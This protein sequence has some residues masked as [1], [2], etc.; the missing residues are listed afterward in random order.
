MW[1]IVLA[2]FAAVPA[3]WWLGRRFGHRAG[4]MLAT[5]P[6]AVTAWLFGQLPL[7][8]GAAREW[9]MAWAP[10]LGVELALR[11]DALS[12]T[13]V[14][15]IS[16]IGAL[17]LIYA[18]GYLAGDPRIGRLLATLL[19]FMGAMLG[20]VLADDPITLFV[21]WELTSVASYLLVGFDHERAASRA[22][23]L[24]A[25]L[26][27]GAGGLALLAGLILLAIAAG[28]LGL[29]RVRLSALAG[30]GLDGHVL[31]PAIVALILA[32]AVTKSA[33]VP[34]HFW[35]P[36]AMAA[37]T[38]VSAYLHSA[39]MVKAGVYLLARLHPALGGTLAWE[40]PVT[41]V[42]AA[43]MVVGAV[44]TLGQRDLKRILAYSTVA[45]LGILTMLLGL[46]T[47][48][49]VKTAVVFLVAHALYKA[50]LFMVAGS[51]DHETGTRDVTVL[52]GLRRAMP[53]TAAA[54]VL[55]ALS[56]AGAPPMF[57][58]IGKELLYTTKLD[59]DTVAAWLILAAVLA[60]V[61]L[62]ASALLVSVRPFL[63]RRKETPKPPHEAPPAMVLG[64]VVLAGLGPVIGLAPQAFEDALG[65]GAASAVLGRPVVMKLALWHG[66]HL[67]ALAVLGLS[68]ATLGLGWLLYRGLRRRLARTA[69][70]AER[71]GRIG[72][73][74]AFEA[75][76]DGLPGVAGWLTARVQTGFLRHALMV[77]VA[78]TLAA[79]GPPVV[80]LL[81]AGVE[82]PG[83]A[84]RAHEL[85][86]AVLVLGGAIVAAVLRSRLGA[87]AA[88]GASGIGIAL[89]FALYGAPDLALT[90]VMVESLSVILLVLVF[91]RL[92]RVVRRSGAGS[93]VRDLGIA[94]AAGGLMT[95]LVLAAAAATHLDAGISRYFLETSV[96]GAYGRNVVNVILV[97][98]RALDTLGEITVVAV[99]G[100]GILALLR[101]GGTGETR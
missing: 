31:Y 15:L 22:A 6:A 74:R 53:W 56:K 94:L 63:G 101:R 57:G 97:D 62:V 7:A 14:L 72:P 8:P 10:G 87:V 70:V 32:G 29:E 27:T 18:G 30:I 36:E 67:E 95:A 79:A 73:T 20:V 75:G 47:E 50:A 92:P 77:A 37:P 49:A 13:F 81:R 2:P 19:A 11:L 25:L 65:S 34:F 46:G 24:K 21:F 3:A 68:A 12:A 42:G 28:D 58:F 64:P 80:R 16:G 40:I 39:T 35:L 45:V 76:V 33:Q 98:F 48:L 9:S 51:V 43:T 66:F 89:L 61:A 55:A 4:W 60:N 52:G 82:L 78:A 41:A 23:A 44:L 91:A 90:Q 5:V 84:P 88:L 69:E 96:P 83:P 26:V 85:A 17:V 86:L 59:L 100:L 71:L 54:G 93:R 99:A 1:M 38:P